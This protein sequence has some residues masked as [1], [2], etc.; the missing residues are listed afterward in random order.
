MNSD[1]HDYVKAEKLGEEG[2]LCDKIFRNC[3]KSLMDIF[4]Q[5]YESEL[6][7]FDWN[8]YKLISS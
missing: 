8:I 4:T 1:H 7:K 6:Y 3:R 2:E 5:V